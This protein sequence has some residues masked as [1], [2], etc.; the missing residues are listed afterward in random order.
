MTG[1]QTCALPILPL[2]AANSVGTGSATLGLT[3]VPQAVPTLSSSDYLEWTATV[4][5]SFS[6][7]IYADGTPTGYA[8][9]GLPPDRRKAIRG[10][11]ARP[12]IDDL[13]VFLD[14]SLR[15]L[16]AKSELAKAIRYARARWE[17][18]TRYL[19]DGRQIDVQLDE[20]FVVVGSEDDGVGEDED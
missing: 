3:V 16:S 5:A 10:E 6:N 8:A 7:Y 4:G 2:T 17:A 13:A 14:A 15:K 19:D 11:Q 12:A 20:N 1:V 18:L 9:S